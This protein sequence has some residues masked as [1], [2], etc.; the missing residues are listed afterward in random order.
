[1]AVAHHAWLIELWTERIQ[2][3]HHRFRAEMLHHRRQGMEPQHRRILVVDPA[4]LMADDDA[5][6]RQILRVWH[7]LV[8][9]NVSPERIRTAGWLRLWPWLANLD[10]RCVSIDPRL[11]FSGHRQSVAGRPCRRCEDDILGRRPLSHTDLR[12]D[13]VGD[14]VSRRTQHEHLRR[15]GWLPKRR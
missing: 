1:M 12:E 8:W 5:E 11:E 13:I 14:A 2:K 4:E 10:Q 3:R 6:L 15:R 9:V 7:L